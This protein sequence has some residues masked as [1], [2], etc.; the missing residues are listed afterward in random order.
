[1]HIHGGDVY[2][3]KDVIDFSANINLKGIPQG[4]IDAAC[5]GV[6]M[7]IH[8]PDVRCQE[9]REALSK[10]ENLPIEYI[11]CGNGAADVIFSLVLA[12]KPSKALLPAP[13]FYEYEQALRAVGCDISYFYLKEDNYFEFDDSIFELTEDSTDI[14]FLCNPNNPTGALADKEFLIKLVNKCK[15][16]NVLLV[17]DECFNDFLDEP[18][19]YSMTEEL[20]Q[21]DNLFILKAFTKIYAIPGLRLGYGLCSNINILDKMKE[22]SQPWSVS[23]PAQMAGVAA[24][25][26]KE[27]V[28]ESKKEIKKERKFLLE[29]LKNMGFTTFG[30][31]ANYIFFRAWEKLSKQTEEKDI[32]IRDCSNYEGLDK[33]YFRIAV[34]THDD[35]EKLIN[36][37]KELKEERK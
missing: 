9:L 24:L 17:L 1:M 14:M 11:R 22:V 34:R 8:Y 35:N 12:M 36:L 7:S 26:E 21:H 19:K 29:N 20:S 18:E 23:I 33:G 30:S 16:K 4:I 10:E 5:K 25:K 27:Y 6:E 37:L 15:E 13:T 2:R 3:K 28:I 32:L 31:H